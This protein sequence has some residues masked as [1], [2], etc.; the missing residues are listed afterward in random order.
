MRHLFVL[1]IH[2]IAVLTQ[3]LQPGGVRSLVAESFLLNHLW[4][5]I[6]PLTSKSNRYE[7]Q[8]PLILYITLVQIKI[9]ICERKKA[10]HLL[11]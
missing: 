4:Y 10:E 7:R 1:F 9:S 3:L 11:A 2:L 5:A 8:T 6:I